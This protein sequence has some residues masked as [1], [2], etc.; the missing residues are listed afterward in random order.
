MAMMAKLPAFL[1]LLITL[2]PAAPSVDPGTTT[3]T[4]PTSTN[5]TD[6]DWE[7]YIASLSTNTTE[8]EDWGPQDDEYSN[9]TE[10]DAMACPEGH[11]ANGEECLMDPSNCPNGYYVL[12]ED[13]DDE[14][15]VPDGGEFG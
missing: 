6:T 14:A 11:I 15:C 10:I 8:W 3:T 1:L 13:Q 12:Y 5:T 4:A 2:T 7:D 9:E